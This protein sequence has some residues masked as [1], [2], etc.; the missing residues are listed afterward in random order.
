MAKKQDGVKAQV[1]LS[2]SLKGTAKVTI[3]LW[4]I[5]LNGT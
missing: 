3:F 4:L 2:P 5:L 1:V